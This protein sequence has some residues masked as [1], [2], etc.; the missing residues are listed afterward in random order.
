MVMPSRDTN[1]YIPWLIF[2]V[3]LTSITTQVLLMRE[4]VVVFYGNELSAGVMLGIW[5]F[6]TALG[7]SLLPRII[8]VSHHRRRS[9]ALLQIVIAFFLP[10]ILILV[11]SS[12]QI[13]GITLG[14]MIGFVPMLLITLTTLA[15]FC[16]LNGMLYTLACGL[17]H[18][19]ENKASQAIGKV[20]LWEALGAGIGGLAA[21][22]VFVRLFDPPY[23][24]LALALLNLMTALILGR[25]IACFSATCRNSVV[26]TVFV[27]GC[28]CFI[29]FGPA[30]RKISQTIPWAG[31]DLV[32]TR[33]TIYGNIGVTRFGDQYS[34]FQNG[35][36]IYT[37]P[38]RLTAEE[39]VHFA[40]L[41]HLGPQRVLLI[42]GGLGGSITETLRHPSIERVD[43]VELDPGIV[44]LS[45]CV[46][47]PEHTRSLDD[48]R[49]HIHHIDGR[50]FIKSTTD[51]FDVIILNFPNPYTAQLNRFYTLEF[52]REVDRRLS[53]SGVF[54]L[55]VQ[56]SENAIGPE[57][58]DFLSTLSATLTHVFPDLV[59]IPGETNRFIVSNQ[60]DYL[61]EN[62]DIL[63]QRLRE[64]NLQTLY[65]REYYVPY[66]MTQE[67]QEYLQCQIHPVGPNR[68]NRDFRPIGY[69]YDTI[70]WAT[71]F[72]SGFKRLFLA[73]ADIKFQHIAGLFLLTAVLVILIFWRPASRS[74]L[75]APS[76][77]YSVLGVGF[78]E[79]SLEVV[80]ILGFQV[81]YGY[82]YQQL[83]VIVAGYMVGLALGSWLAVSKNVRD[84][85]AF[86]LFRL[87]QLGMIFYPLLIA[88]IFYSLHTAP[89]PSAASWMSWLFPSLAAGAGF[90]GGYQFP[91][92]N[93]LYLRRTPSIHRVAGLLYGSDL[94]G[95]SAGAILVSTFIIPLLGIFPTLF[96][97]SV[98]NIFSFIVISMSRE[99]PPM[100]NV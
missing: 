86:P 30:F 50:R 5:L 100:E 40:L 12:R 25:F 31:Y 61:T 67:R 62:P 74:R 8:R 13:L 88:G 99:L 69:Y 97:L 16:L 1:R 42:G 36:L 75:F 64:R 41:E 23:V 73:M 20:Y 65:V 58:S 66:Q 53:A 81:L 76:L 95:S 78:T 83:A 63:V 7:S 80:L 94:L 29:R 90:I 37:A 26:A 22:L 84:E 17:V 43:Y 57:L 77:L 3:G 14:E 2:I 38:D 48:S 82:A 47:P 89:N 6:W 92:A 11:R 56:S 24:F 79:I 49:V 70:L 85:K 28:L 33:N 46:L 39:S 55:H 21:S 10:F 32:A 87:C 72:S 34:F 52:F 54:A 4:L 45:E 27:L 93:R 18:E 98:L 68:L 15:P 51:T 19:T 9:I 91:L 44:R 35:L 71:Y 96:L 60:P 59:I